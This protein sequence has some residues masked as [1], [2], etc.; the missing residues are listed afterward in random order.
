M[1]YCFKRNGFHHFQGNRMRGNKIISNRLSCQ[2][3]NVTETSYNQK[4]SLKKKKRGEE[5]E[6]E[7]QT[8]L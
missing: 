7:I 8:L 6:R 4:A 1:P 2:S 5:A 3:L